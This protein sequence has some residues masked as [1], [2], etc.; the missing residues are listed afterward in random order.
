ME[1]SGDLP[2]S[3]IAKA[4]WALGARIYGRWQYMW[5][6]MIFCLSVFGL[7]VVFLSDWLFQL[8]QFVAY[9]RY[10]SWAFL[11]VYFALLAGFVLVCARY[12]RWV[13]AKSTR[14]RGYRNVVPIRFL[15][16]EDGF[17]VTAEFSRTHVSWPGVTEIA[18]MRKRHWLIILAGSGYV[19][20]RRFFANV[21]AERAFIRD[22]L[23]HMSEAARG[24]SKKAV[25][26]AEPA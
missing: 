8:P 9:E 22:A 5:I 13:V 10:G 3:E 17:H 26:F 11:L 19:I 15:V 25:A 18:P 2:P 6:V 12:G 4:K 16:A 1:V 21:E 23:G 14:E 20:P 7:A 24:R